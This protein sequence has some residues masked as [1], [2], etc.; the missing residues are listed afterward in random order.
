[1]LST[2]LS[3]LLVA[4]AALGVVAVFVLIRTLGKLGETA[5]A[6]TGVVGSL[7]ATAKSATAT[8]DEVRATI[9]EVREQ[10]APM[11]V[12]VDVAADAV[13]A[14]LLRLDTIMGD[15]EAT[16]GQVANASH[17]VS[18]LANAPVDAVANLAERFRKAWRVRKAE[19]TEDVARYGESLSH[20]AQQAAHTEYA[21]AGASAPAPVRAPKPATSAAPEVAPAV[22]RQVA[23]V[24]ASE[25]APTPAAAPAPATAV[26][27]SYGYTHDVLAEYVPEP[28]LEVEYLPEPEPVAE[29]E[30]QLQ[31]TPA[32]A[33]APALSL[34]SPDEPSD[35]VVT[36][37]EEPVEPD[38]DDSD[39]DFSSEDI[40]RF[41][42]AAVLSGASSSAA[43]N[44][45]ESISASVSSSLG[46]D[47]EIVEVAPDEYRPWTAT[48]DLGGD[49]GDEGVRA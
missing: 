11:L 30:D 24:A 31:P 41:S 33:P 27:P 46:D 38:V 12:K 19:V 21:P 3:Y 6:L 14:N 45:R 29:L 35:V 18:N 1:M 4:L 28:A 9:T 20:A 48:S 40:S 22:A 7:D 43:A 17:A 23:P 25:P 32:A 42:A 36:K 15:I 47:T 26:E 2:V 34:D 16:T 39:A 8:S 49:A 5:E 44:G 37:F 13:N 10:I